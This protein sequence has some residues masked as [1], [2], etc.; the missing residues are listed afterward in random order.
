[1]IGIQV[2]IGIRAQSVT[3]IRAQSITR[4]RTQAVTRVR[5]QATTRIRTQSITRI[6]AQSINRIRDKASA[7]TGTCCGARM[8]ATSLATYQTL[9]AEGSH[10]SICVALPPLRSRSPALPLLPQEERP[11][12]AW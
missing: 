4:I 5:A 7:R 3:K 8:R 10:S 12:L 6:R 1:M 2:E 11:C 9:D